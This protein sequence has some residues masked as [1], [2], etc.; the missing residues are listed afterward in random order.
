MAGG[1]VVVDGLRGRN[2][3]DVNL[4]ASG[5]HTAGKRSSPLIELL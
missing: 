5:P 2:T 1:A 3:V 4:L